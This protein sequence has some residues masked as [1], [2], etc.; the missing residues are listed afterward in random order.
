VA[1]KLQIV[2]QGLAK[3]EPWIDH[4]A[5]SGNTR[6]AA[7]LN[8]LI[9]ERFDLVQD[10]GV[11]RGVLHAPRVTLHV[12]DAYGTLRGSRDL[13]SPLLAQ[14]PDI[15]DQSRTGFRRR[16]HNLWLTSIDGDDCV[17]LNAQL[18]NDGY[19][20]VDFLFRAYGLG[21]RS[22]GLTT[23]VDDRRALLDHTQA[24]AHGSRYVAKLPTIGK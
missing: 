7:H 22:S 13:Q 20:T 23:H 1:Q 14:R 3:S 15:I 5:V 9:Q 17:G 18:L 10:I 4:N 2:L 6:R 11:V 8:A 12:H 24:V 19:H 16:T 21:A